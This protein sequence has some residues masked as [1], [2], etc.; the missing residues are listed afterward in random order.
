MEHKEAL[1]S[2]GFLGKDIGITCQQG[3][4]SSSF[5]SSTLAVSQRRL[6]HMR[7][8][9]LQ[10]PSEWLSNLGTPDIKHIDKHGHMQLYSLR[11]GSGSGRLPETHITPEYSTQSGKAGDLQRPGE[12]MC[13]K[14]N[15]I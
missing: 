15:S 13:Q 9:L 2:L 5:A 8:H 10:R 4:K 6:S 1:V 7:T 3:G 14:E 11:G 12:R